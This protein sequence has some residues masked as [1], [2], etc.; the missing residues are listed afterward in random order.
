MPDY[1]FHVDKYAF[2]ML[3]KINSHSTCDLPYTGKLLENTE[4]MPKHRWREAVKVFF[5]N[6]VDPER[7]EE[8]RETKAGVHFLIISSNLVICYKHDVSMAL[9]L[10]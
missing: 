6:H 4:N 7:D 3:D 8:L 10:S 5:G 1:T 9:L 2:S